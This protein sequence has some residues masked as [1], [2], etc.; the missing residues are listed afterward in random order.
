MSKVLEKLM[1][2]RSERFINENK[3]LFP[4]QFG[5]RREYST[6]DAVVQFTDYCCR[7]L[8]KKL[9]TIAIFLDFSKA[10]D[11]V[12]KNALLLKLE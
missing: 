3:I 5:F 1:K 11:T 9:Y 2:D 10:F 8:E 4:N 7:S 12:N 6:S